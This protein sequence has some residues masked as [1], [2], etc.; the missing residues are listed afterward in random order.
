MLIPQNEELWDDFR[1][2]L[3]GL[4]RVDL[5]REK[6]A[7]YGKDRLKDQELLAIL[8]G[9]GVQ[10]ANVMVL[11]NRILKVV[12]EKGVDTVSSEDLEQIKGLGKV[13]AAQVIASI[14][15]GRRLLTG[16]QASLIL[17]PEEVWNRTEDIRRSK[18]EHFLVFFLNGRSQEICREVISVGTLNE[19]LVH[20]REVFE[21]AIKNNAASVIFAHNHPSGSL[22][23]S[24]AD[25][26]VTRKLVSAGRIL[27]I[28]VLDHVIVTESVYASIMP[29][30]NI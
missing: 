21:V 27:D 2:R 28:D 4:S 22:E 15:L 11:A 5:P 9:S 1:M 26:L 6:F 20:P 7:K 25:I 19:S 18:K 3:K 29:F 30:I 14:E 16:K 10:G 17:S 8:L 12:A 23:P 13:K 24:E